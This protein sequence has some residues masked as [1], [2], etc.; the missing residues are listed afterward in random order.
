MLNNTVEFTTPQETIIDQIPADVYQ[1]IITD[2]KE[3]QGT[4]FKTGEPKNQLRFTADVVEGDEA[5]KTISFFTSYS[6]FSGG[7]NAKPSKLYNLFKTIYAHYQPEAKVD[8]LP[9]VTASDVNDLIGKQLRVTVE[10]S[11]KG[12]PKVTSFVSIKK[13]LA[14]KPVEPKDDINVDDIP[15]N[16]GEEIN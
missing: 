9:L 16:L 7:K 4:D 5:G 6:W 8:D 1:I 10:V 3:A 13:E 12:W 14:Y 11:E 2:V 15:D